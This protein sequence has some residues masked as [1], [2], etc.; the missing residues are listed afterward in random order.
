MIDPSRG[1]YYPT[2]MR[3]SPL[4]A[5]CVA[6][7]SA[8]KTEPDD[9]DNEGPI[10]P[11]AED[12]FA[13]QAAATLCAQLFA[14]QCGDNRATPQTEPLP[15]ATEAECV[16]EKQPDYQALLDAVLA[17]GGTYS[18]EC[19]GRMIAHSE[20]LDC[21][22]QYAYVLGGGDSYDS[23]VCPLAVNE[24][25][26][27]EPCDPE[28]SFVN[29]CGEGKACSWEDSTCIEVGPLPVPE[30]GLCEVGYVD[31]PCADGLYCL[32]NPE[33]DVNR[34]RPP[35]EVGDP[36]PNYA[37]YGADLTCDTETFTC[38]PNA[39]EGESCMTVGCKAGLYCDGGQDFTCVAQY[40]FGHGCATDAVCADGGRCIDNVCTPPSPAV[41]VQLVNG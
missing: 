39:G 31:L 6:L 36:C 25:E 35:F 5:L 16:A 4:V 7:L 19:G 13:A 14:C 15:W 29:D 2:A 20:R 38:V 34:C 11:V 32:Y 8:C 1:W 12:E 24:R 37:C 18:P 10:E 3:S 23:Q 33:E 40:E 9:P 21:L 41:C 30:G 17:T 26:V 28:L 27:G 22:S